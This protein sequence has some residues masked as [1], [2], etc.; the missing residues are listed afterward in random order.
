MSHSAVAI[1]SPL[2]QQ[3]SK[4]TKLYSM[5]EEVEHSRGGWNFCP[6]YSA[7]LFISSLIQ[8]KMDFMCK[9]KYCS[10]YQH[11][12]QWNLQK[13][14][15]TISYL[16]RSFT[17]AVHALSKNLGATSKFCSPWHDVYSMLRTLKY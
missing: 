5:T 8:V 6:P 1:L 3:W 14:C 16:D 12:L 10:E 17:A 11:L 4:H 13:F 2:Y 15:P 9:T 7:V